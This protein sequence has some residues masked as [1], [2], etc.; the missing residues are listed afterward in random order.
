MPDVLLFLSLREAEYFLKQGWTHNCERRP[1]GKSSLRLRWISIRARTQRSRLVGTAGP[2]CLYILLFSHRR[3]SRVLDRSVL[4]FRPSFASSRPKRTACTSVNIESE[5]RFSKPQFSA[6]DP[7][8]WTSSSRRSQ[9]GR[10]ERM[11]D[12]GLAHSVVKDFSASVV[13][14]SGAPQL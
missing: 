6:Q 9:Q 14:Q 1:S 4:K 11:I 3:V 12:H 2:L 10:E 5:Y 8:Q 13:R 7:N